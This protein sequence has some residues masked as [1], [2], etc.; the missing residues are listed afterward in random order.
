M[1]EIKQYT[2]PVLKVV[3]FQ[4]EHGFAGS[5]I[6]LSRRIDEEYEDFND[7]N[8]E[9]WTEDNSLFGGTG[10]DSGW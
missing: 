5:D 3:S 4:V 9:N 6:R 2:A 7:Q 1:K 8:Q 10:W